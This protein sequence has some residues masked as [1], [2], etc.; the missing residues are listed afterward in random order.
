[1]SKYYPENLIFCDKCE[2]EFHTQS[3][4]DNHECELRSALFEAKKRIRELEELIDSLR[5]S[6]MKSSE[7]GSYG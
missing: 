7:D 4:F 1:M 2:V 5:D 3:S 6:S